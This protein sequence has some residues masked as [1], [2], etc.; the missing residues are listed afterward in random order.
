MSFDGDGFFSLEVEAFRRD[1]R[2]NEPF[3]ALS[4]E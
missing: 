3:K 4:T 2:E 1:V